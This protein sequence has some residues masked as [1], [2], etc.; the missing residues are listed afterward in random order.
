MANAGNHNDTR[1]LKSMIIEGK[2]IKIYP[3]DHP[4]I[5]KIKLRFNQIVVND[6]PYN[7]NY[8]GK[9]GVGHSAWKDVDGTLI[10]VNQLRTKHWYFENINK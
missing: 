7:Y 8:F 2:L 1:L 9:K 10:W 5:K 6:Q 3:N 4:V